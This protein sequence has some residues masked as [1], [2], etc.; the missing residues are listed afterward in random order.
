MP[1][2]RRAGAGSARRRLLGLPG[3]L[4]AL[5]SLLLAVAT[6]SPAA[7]HAALTAIEPGDGTTVGS[8]PSAVRLTF[9]EAVQARFVTVVVTAPTGDRVDGP[10]PQVVGSTVS[11]PLGPLPAAGRYAVSYRIVSADGHPVSGQSAFTYT[12]AGPASGPATGPAA[13]PTSA[14]TG[15]PTTTPAPTASRSPAAGTATDAA[16]GDRA[17]ANQRRVLLVV[18]VLAAVLA[19]L[20]ADRRRTRRRGG[21]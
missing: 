19:L 13:G 15:A 3:A 14:P 7:A 9:S 8:A 16:G 6:A 11:V 10:P 17:G 18:A 21:R 1:S 4:V 20:V 5:L 12:P 2:A